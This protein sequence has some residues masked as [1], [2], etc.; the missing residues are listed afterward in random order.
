MVGSR[1]M[2]TGPGNGASQNPA[3]RPSPDFFS[4]KCS[5]SSVFTDTS[6]IGHFLS[7]F[8][9]FGRSHNLSTTERSLHAVP[10]NHIAEAPGYL[11]GKCLSLRGG[12]LPR[13]TRHDTPDQHIRPGDGDAGLPAMASQGAPSPGHQCFQWLWPTERPDAGRAKLL[14]LEAGARWGDP[15]ARQ[16]APG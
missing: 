8:R 5:I 1:E 9:H 6:E 16:S 4:T 7:I 10:I 3:Y 14:S 2:I 15:H 13:P 11:T 12:R